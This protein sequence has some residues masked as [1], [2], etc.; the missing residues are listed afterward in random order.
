VSKGELEAPEFATGSK[1]EIGTLAEAFGRMRKS[2]VHA[3][4][5]L[6]S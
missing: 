1:D 6:D 4:K 3:M 5:M 2:L